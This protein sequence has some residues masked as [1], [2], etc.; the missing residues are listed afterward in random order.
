V[1]AFNY[2]VTQYRDGFSGDDIANG[3]V[4]DIAEPMQ[5]ITVHGVGKSEMVRIAFGAFKG[6]LHGLVRADSLND[7]IVDAIDGGLR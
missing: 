4:D 1:V 2:Y 5:V 7:G 6:D 3:L